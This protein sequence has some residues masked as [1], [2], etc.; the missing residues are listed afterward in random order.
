MI[1]LGKGVAHSS[2]PTF[3]MGIVMLQ[4]IYTHGFN[5]HEVN[6][7]LLRL[8]ELKDALKIGDGVIER[9][10]LHYAIER[11]CAPNQ[12]PNSI[13]HI[14]N[15]YPIY[16]AQAEMLKPTFEYWNRQESG[17]QDDT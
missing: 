2:T 12:E 4:T 8:A 1:Q 6:D 5:R 3:Y 7:F 15:L 17:V 16:E 11:F 9:C 10:K 13:R 14:G